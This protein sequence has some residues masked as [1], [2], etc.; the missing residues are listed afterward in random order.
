MKTILTLQQYK[1]PLTV[2]ARDVAAGRL[3]PCLEEYGI[4]WKRSFLSQDCLQMWCQ[5][6]ATDAEAVRQACR[7]ADIPLAG[8]WQ[9]Q[10]RESA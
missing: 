7:S 5:F 9:V 3:N 4:T 2:E 6:E 10:L 1:T 8:V